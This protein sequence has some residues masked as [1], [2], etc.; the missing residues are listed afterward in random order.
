MNLL[1]RLAWARRADAEPEEADEVEDIIAT[2]REDESDELA[3]EVAGFLPML[4]ILTTQLRDIAAEVEHQVVK[5][6]ASLTGIVT[7][8]NDIAKSALA[9]VEGS[10]TGPSGDALIETTRDVVH[11]LLDRMKDSSAFSSDTAERLQ[12]VES[13][14][15]SVTESL[16]GVNEIAEIAKV[17][18]LN[19]RIEAA[20]AGEYGAAFSVVATETGSLANMAMETNLR[21]CETVHGLN[22][23]LSETSA[24]IQ[25]RQ[26]NDSAELTRCYDLSDEI[27]HYLD[28]YNVHVKEC[29]SLLTASRGSVAQEVSNAVVALQFQDSVNQR[30]DH[31]VNAINSIRERVE[32][33]VQDAN[34]RE[35]EAKLQEWQTQ[36]RAD[37][38]MDSERVVQ[39]GA[40]ATN[41]TC[42]IEL[43]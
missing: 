38:T 32:P 21:V 3:V 25:E 14:L 42:D 39:D 12:N 9:K 11:G 23:V 18:A 8:T 27:L 34:R 31:V 40:D 22:Q 36:M 20:R 2:N 19:G 35:A 4:E 7:Q 1:T 29:L 17:V 15:G 28:D 13:E 5:S 26:A 43:F 16:V 6:C 24:M 10:G 33:L 30:I 41:D 37:Y